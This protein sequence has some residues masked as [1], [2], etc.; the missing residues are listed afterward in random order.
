MAQVTP[1][2]YWRGVPENEV[3]LGLQL[4]HTDKVLDVTPVTGA[5]KIAV[6]FIGFTEVEDPLVT[7]PFRFWI[8]K[9]LG[10]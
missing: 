7:M 6:T 8:A 9:V 2:T 10:S 3:I 5:L 4:P 1:N